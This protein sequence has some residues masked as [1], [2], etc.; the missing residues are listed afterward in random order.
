MTHHPNHPSRRGGLRAFLITCASSALLSMPLGAAESDD[1]TI[2]LSPFEVSTEKDLGYYTSNTLAGTRLNT[3]LIKTPAA[4]SVFND[5]FLKDIGANTLV[6]ALEY[7]M[8]FSIDVTSDNG[9]HLQF[10]NGGINA[11]GFPRAEDNSRD[12][13][14]SVVS[15]DRYN[16]ERLTLTRGPNS[17]LFGIGNPGGIIDATTKRARFS[18]LT[19]FEL[20]VDQWGTFRASG[21]VNRVLI[22]NKLAARINYLHE[23]FE[24]NREFHFR[25]TERG[26]FALT[27]TPFRSTT[28]RADFER[29]VVERSFQRSWIARDG[30]SVWQSRGENF[31]DFRKFLNSNGSYNLTAARTYATSVGA[32]MTSTD[33]PVLLWNG[34]GLVGINAR[35]TVRSTGLNAQPMLLELLDTWSLDRG[36]AGPYNRSDHDFTAYSAIVEQRIGS[37]LILEA[38]FKRETENRYVKTTIN[39]GHITPYVDLAPMLPDGT[40]NPNYNRYFMESQPDGNGQDRTSTTG[41]LTASYELTPGKAWL[42]RHRFAALLQQLERDQMSTRALW[43][44][45][46]PIGSNNT[47]TGNRLSNRTYIDAPDR[48]GGERGFMADPSTYSVAP[49]DLRDPATGAVLGKVTPALVRDRER[50]NNDKTKTWMLAG[51]SSF[52]NERIVFTYGHRSDELKQ[53]NFVEYKADAAYVASHPGTLRDQII[54]SDLASPEIFKGDTRSLGI[55]VQPL[56]WLTLTGNRSENFSPQTRF[57]I[58]NE[59]IGN[60]TATGT[61]FSARLALAENKLV[62]IAN[63]F[64]TDVLNANQNLYD[65]FTRINPIWEALAYHGRVTNPT[66]IIENSV[67]SKDFTAKGWEYE[68]IANPTRSLT[69][70]ASFTKRDNIVSDVGREVVAYMEKNLPIWTPHRDLLLIDTTN[71]TIGS[72]I[73]EVTQRLASD[74]REI[75]KGSSDNIRQR[76]NLFGKYTFRT[77]W[78]KGFDIGLGARFTGERIIGYVAEADG[79]STAQTSESFWIADLKLGYKTKI[80][81]DR[82]TLDIRLNVRNLLDYDDPTVFTYVAGTQQAR[83][84]AIQDKRTVSLTTSI[85]F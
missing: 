35:H 65:Y 16:T 24:T 41:R 79:S 29:G 55:A 74:R 10:G 2:M 85:S 38:G 77:G 81:G 6:E 49:F 4:V 78:L 26:H 23:Q 36:L 46:T 20:G 14:P 12:F 56:R 3:S 5:D 13:F 42:G 84:Y 28:I 62:F 52:W 11:R 33:T 67:Y 58:N 80:R 27:Y 19:Q 25:N 8:A 44:N 70:R 15:T 22:K 45:T 76:I 47:I 51:Q 54:G 82:N 9:N 71:K 66:L 21:D 63:R 30:V 69:L 40:P 75:S 68:L 37:D 7:S 50:P 72:N 60:I 34:S 73:D 43:V 18:A 53:R 1:A 32:N 39:H 59:N 48:P 57:N 61:D 83:T 31:V 17:I 64:E